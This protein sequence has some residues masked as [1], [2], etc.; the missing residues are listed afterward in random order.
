MS[1]CCFFRS[2]QAVFSSVFWQELTKKQ[3]LSPA[4]LPSL[5]QLSQASNSGKRLISIIGILFGDGL[6][7]SDKN[8]FI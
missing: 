2:I 7:R 5:S 6:C 3:R 8:L 4:V 1:G